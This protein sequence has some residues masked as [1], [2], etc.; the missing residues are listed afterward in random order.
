VS[1][2]REEKREQKRELARQLGVAGK[3]VPSSLLEH[4]RVC[5][6]KLVV[7]ALDV[8]VRKRGFF[9]AKVPLVVVV[10]LFVVDRTAAKTGARLVRQARVDVGVVSAGV[11]VDVAKKAD[12]VGDE[13]VRYH[14]PGHFVVVAVAAEAA[15]D[16]GVLAGVDA[17]AIATDG[18]LVVA[19][20]FAAAGVVVDA[21]TTVKEALVVPLA[22]A[23]G[24]FA[25]ALRMHVKL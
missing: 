25:G 10:G 7:D 14:R 5:E 16:A 4:E 24:R 3:D 9:E 18:A 15:V 22:S 20:A 6:P 19:G 13:R 8:A 23:D 11:S 12:V 21:V 1:R 2:K 17:A